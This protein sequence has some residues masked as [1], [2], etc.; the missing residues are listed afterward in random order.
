MSFSTLQPLQLIHI[1]IINST[2]E[3][4]QDTDNTLLTSSMRLPLQRVAHSSIR[5]DILA[6]FGLMVFSCPDRTVADVGV[7]TTVPRRRRIDKLTNIQYSLL[8]VVTLT[9]DRISDV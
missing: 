2:A 5:R 1:V 9:I 6:L 7:T 4:R 3:R 8:T